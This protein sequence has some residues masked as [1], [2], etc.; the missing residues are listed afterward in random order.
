MK[1]NGNND[2][3]DDGKKSHKKVIKRRTAYKE[4]TEA[5]NLAAYPINGQYLP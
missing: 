4:N 3:D 5:G 2:D 1:K